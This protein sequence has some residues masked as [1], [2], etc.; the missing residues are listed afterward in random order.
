MLL[1]KA[2]ALWLLILFC[3]VLN[4]GFRE[5]VLLPRLGTPSALVLSGVLLCVCIVAVSLLFGRWLGLIG[6]W[7]ALS[8]GLLWLCLTLA[9][10]FGFGRLVQDQSWPE[11]LQAYKFQ[12][13]NIWPL[14]LVVTLFAPLL[15]VRA[16]GRTQGEP[17]R[18]A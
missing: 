8:V 6:N 1:L 7:Q 5:A 3:A 9:F 10:E 15:A 4:G 13:G 11:M 17:Q 16:R 14:V 18:G 2:S 12:D